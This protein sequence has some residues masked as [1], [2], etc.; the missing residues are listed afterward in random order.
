VVPIVESFF[1]DAKTKESR[2]R[3]PDGTIFL[4][5]LQHLS[6][7]YGFLTED[8]PAAPVAQ[9]IPECI[10]SLKEV[11]KACWKST[12]NDKNIIEVRVSRKGE[13]GW[14]E[15][16]LPRPGTVKSHAVQELIDE[17]HDE[18]QRIWVHP[19]QEMVDIYTG[20]ISS[21]AGAY[22]QYFSTMVFVN[23]EERALAYNALGGLLKSCKR[24]DISLATLQQI[25][26]N[27]VLVPAEF[28]GYCG[29]RKLSD[30]ITRMVSF[31]GELQGKE[32]YA[33]LLSALTVYANK[34]NG[35]SLHY[36][37]WVHGKEHAYN[38]PL[39]EQPPGPIL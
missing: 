34:I 15:Y 32:E 20:N 2:S 37:P 16:R 24:S 8:L 33:T 11:G 13:G 31:L 3:S 18:T 27:F 23:G 30:F 6:I 12:F 4:S 5:Y 22:N 10:Q 21:R 35:W 29:L 28:L 36:F 7:K 1:A 38:K 17:I 19:P 26:P 25:T 14:T 9:V 39:A